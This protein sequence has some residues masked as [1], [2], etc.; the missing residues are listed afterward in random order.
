MFEKLRS[1]P[2]EHYGMGIGMLGFFIMLV[3]GLASFTYFP[4]FGFYV[5]AFGISIGIIGGFL[6]FLIN[7]KEIFRGDS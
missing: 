3:G 6:H 2:S 1:I 7:W 5:A 4:I